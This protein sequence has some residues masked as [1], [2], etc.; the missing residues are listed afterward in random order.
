MSVKPFGV[1]IDIYADRDI[2]GDNNPGKRIRNQFVNENASLNGA[3]FSR[4]ILQIGYDFVQV[5]DLLFDAR[6]KIQ[7]LL[8]VRVVA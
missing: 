1:T 2:I 8:F 3:L 7:S 4:V 5:K 6:T